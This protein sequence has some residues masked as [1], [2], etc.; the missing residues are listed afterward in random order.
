MP[1]K[2]YPPNPIYLDGPYITTANGG[3]TSWEELHTKFR[4]P[5]ELTVSDGT[6]RNSGGRL[7]ASLRKTECSFGD[8]KLSSRVEPLVCEAAAAIAMWGSGRSFL[9]W[10][11][12]SKFK[13]T[14]DSDS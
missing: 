11:A 8:V 9:G 13:S 6:T 10:I 7:E 2:N 4:S 12:G 3:S 5:A 1:V 14:S